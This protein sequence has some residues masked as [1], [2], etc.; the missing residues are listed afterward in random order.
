MLLIAYLVM[1]AIYRTFA[2]IKCSLDDLMVIFDQWFGDRALELLG[3]GGDQF[4]RR[5]MENSRKRFA[6][7]IPICLHHLHYLFLVYQLYC[8]CKPYSFI[9]YL[10]SIST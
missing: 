3:R 5:A 8:D 9:F 10:V 1:N 6:H 7:L 2:R 4:E